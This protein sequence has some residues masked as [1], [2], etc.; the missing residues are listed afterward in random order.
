MAGVKK[1]AAAAT[2]DDAVGEDEAKC[3]CELTLTVWRKQEWNKV[4]GAAN[5][6]V[7]QGGTIGDFELRKS[8]DDKPLVTGKML[9][10]AGPSSKVQGSDARVMPGTYA[11]I[12]N[13]GSKGPYRIVQMTQSEATS[14]FGTRGA[15]N[16]H[17]G[18]NPVDLE[19]CLLPGGASAN[20]PVKVP[21]VGKAKPT[22]QYYPSISGSQAKL[23]EI[24]DAIAKYGV[25][26]SKTTYDGT[27]KYTTTTYTNVKVVIVEIVSPPK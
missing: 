18:N 11:L 24:K 25:T 1:A 5:E 15:V 26:E 17:G 14:H 21:G 20:N 3:P 19:G 22:T 13:P 9:E 2:G 10:A 7:Q 27:E 4:P 12:K 6:N 23:T 8:G 16:I